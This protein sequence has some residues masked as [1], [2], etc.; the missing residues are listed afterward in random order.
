MKKIIALV[1]IML[2]SCT[3]YA[4]EF[5]T[6]EKCTLDVNGSFYGDVQPWHY[7]FLCCKDVTYAPVDTF[8][9]SFGY[10]VKF[11][12]RTNTYNLTKAVF[13]GSVKF[14]QTKP[15][16]R[17]SFEELLKNPQKYIGRQVSVDGYFR[18][19]FEEDNLFL[20]YDDYKYYNSNNSI[21]LNFRTILLRSLNADIGDLSTISGRYVTIQGIFKQLWEYPERYMLSHINYVEAKG[22]GTR[23]QKYENFTEYEEGDYKAE[24]CNVKLQLDGKIYKPLDEYGNKAPVFKYNGQI[25]LPLRTYAKAFDLHIEYDEEREEI[26]LYRDCNMDLKKYTREGVEYDD[27]KRDFVSI[28]NLLSNPQVYADKYLSINGALKD[29]KLYL[30]T[31]YSSD[32]IELEPFDG[33]DEFEESFVWVVGEFKKQGDKYII[34]ADY[35]EQCRNTEQYPCDLYW[36]QWWEQ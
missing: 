22:K 10:D 34:I 2:I 24:I 19:A 20:T 15:A 36:D 13:D 28:V 12:E 17:I 23:L 9:Q 33:L 31:T 26:D 21:L 25:Y 11:N 5:I 7:P 3:G 6:V 18:V 4:N 30:D 35:M 29:G 1:L 14:G 16:I 27:R 8:A 32:Y